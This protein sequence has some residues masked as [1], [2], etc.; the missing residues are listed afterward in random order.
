MRRVTLVVLIGSLLVALVAGVAVAKTFR[1]GDNESTPDNPCYGT[2]ERDRIT[3]RDG[4]QSDFIIA[5]DGP[6]LIRAHV[7]GND[8]DN[9]F[10]NQK[11]DRILADDGDDRDTIDCGPGN[12]IAIVDE[13]DAVNVNCEDGNFTDLRG[14]DAE[15]FGT[16]AVE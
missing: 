6:D 14:I 7:R 4:S 2:N 5:R 15:G 12:D 9:L 16:A 13:G 10:G 8:N 1:C 11:G 3:E